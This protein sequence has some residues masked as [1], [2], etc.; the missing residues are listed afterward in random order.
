MLIARYAEKA[1]NMTNPAEYSISFFLPREKSTNAPK[2]AEYFITFSAKFPFAIKLSVDY[3]MKYLFINI[4]F[5]LLIN[6]LRK[7]IYFFIGL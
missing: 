7:S 4:L 5:F 2:S 1:G 6:F 3:K